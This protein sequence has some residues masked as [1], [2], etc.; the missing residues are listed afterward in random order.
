MKESNGWSLVE[1]CSKSFQSLYVCFRIFATFGMWALLIVG[2]FTPHACHMRRCWASVLSLSLDKPFL[3]SINVLQDEN[4]SG[5]N[6]FTSLK[7]VGFFI[8]HVC[9]MLR[10]WACLFFSPRQSINHFYVV[11]TFSKMMKNKLHSTEIGLVAVT[12]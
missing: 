1:I 12:F 4:E 10:C 7:F 8:P 9:H 2:L 6:I 3:H 5:F 11:Y